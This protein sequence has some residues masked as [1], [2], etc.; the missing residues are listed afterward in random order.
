MLGEGYWPHSVLLKGLAIR[1]RR[2]EKHTPKAR[3]R[4]SR[5]RRP[6]PRDEPQHAALL[7][8]L[9]RIDRNMHH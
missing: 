7:A 5:P 6:R 3:Q 4:H 8:N 1:A 2:D 9:A